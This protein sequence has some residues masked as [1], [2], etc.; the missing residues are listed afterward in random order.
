MYKDPSIEYINYSHDVRGRII[1]SIAQMEQRIDWYIA[2]YF[3]NDLSKRTELMETIIST[4]HLT[5]QAKAEI[6]KSLL[7]RN[8]HATKKEANY[9]YNNLINV[10]AKKRNILAHCEVDTSLE[11]V[12]LFQKDKET[13][14]FLRFLNEKKVETFNKKDTI[15]LLEMTGN[16]WAILPALEQRVENNNKPTKK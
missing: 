16:I 12:R 3:C 14:S 11:A 10:I 7:E 15:E 13:V 5:F 6:M 9:V 1:N 8:G 4:K 2:D